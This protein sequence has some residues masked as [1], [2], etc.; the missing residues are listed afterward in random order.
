MWG[1]NVA[2]N[3]YDTGTINNKSIMIQLSQVITQS[4]E[5][6]WQH[7]AQSR[8]RTSL[9]NVT[10]L[11]QDKVVFLSYRQ[12]GVYSLIC[13]VISYITIKAQFAT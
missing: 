10:K 5:L 4:Y 11:C 2:D 12:Y 9:R 8:T 1:L 6:L 3:Y 7:V 13:N